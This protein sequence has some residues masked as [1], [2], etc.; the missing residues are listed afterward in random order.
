MNA[1]VLQGFPDKEHAIS[2]I[3]G[4]RGCCTPDRGW[5]RRCGADGSWTG[6]STSSFNSLVN[7]TWVVQ[8]GT[9]ITHSA[10]HSSNVCSTLDIKLKGGKQKALNLDQSKVKASTAIASGSGLQETYDFN[11]AFTLEA[12]RSTSHPPSFLIIL[13]KTLSFNRHSIS[14][15]S[16]RDSKSASML[17]DP[18]ICTA[19][20]QSCLFK[21]HNQ[22]SLAMS[23][24]AGLVLPLLFIHATMVLLSDWSCICELN[25][26]LHNDCKANKAALS[27]RQLIWSEVSSAVHIPPVVV[28]RHSA[29][30]PIFEA[31]DFTITLDL[32]LWTGDGNLSTLLVHHRRSSRTQ[33]GTL[34]EA[35]KLPQFSERA[36]F[37]A[38]SILL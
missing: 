22:M 23:L 4:R 18:G 29:P 33:S 34:M 12:K 14:C 7:H 25:L 19:D 10:W 30:H 16:T 35:S 3:F 8:K 24:Q 20:T 5:L 17:V 36:A 11:C 1:S 28:P 37:L 38:I 15:L 9:T 21:H 27:S 6:K 26:S 32:L 13:R 31:S 2:F